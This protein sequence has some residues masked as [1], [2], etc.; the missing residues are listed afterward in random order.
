M[1]GS[2]HGR[3]RALIAHGL[4]LNH[5]LV[6]HYPAIPIGTKQDANLLAED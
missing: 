6:S 3:S 4:V 1:N 5:V 2:P